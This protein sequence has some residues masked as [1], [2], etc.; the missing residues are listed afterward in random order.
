MNINMRAL[1]L[2]LNG[3]SNTWRNESSVLNSLAGGHGP[4][5]QCAWFRA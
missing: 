3:D 4:Y 2:W 5:I 1:I